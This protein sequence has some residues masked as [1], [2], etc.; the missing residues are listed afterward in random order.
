M[1][2]IARDMAS[3]VECSAWAAA[4]GIISSSKTADSK[5]I[6]VVLLV[7][8][9][10]P[11]ALHMAAVVAELSQLEFVQVAVVDS[12]DEATRA[13]N[14]SVHSSPAMMIYFKGEP[15]KIVRVGWRE[16]DKLMGC[17][18]KENLVE[19]LQFARQ[20]GEEGHDSI[21]IEW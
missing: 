9:W 5:P 11:P 1:G 14:P 10:C 4:A 7:Q 2:L 21:S 12:D 16:D 8:Q 15:M 18:S 13:A 19:L 17:S 3:A 6:V 20:R